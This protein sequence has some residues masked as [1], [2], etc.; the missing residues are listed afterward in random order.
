MKKYVIKKGQHNSGIHL[1]I[2]FKKEI[3][4]KRQVLFDES[5]EYNIQNDD[6]E[7]VNKLFGVSFGLHHK[8]SARFGWRWSVDKRKIEILTYT[9]I[10]GVRDFVSLQF[11][12]L[13]ETL[14]LTLIAKADTYYFKIGTSELLI[15]KN[16]SPS[17]GYFLYPY[18]GGNKVAPHNIIIN[19]N[20]IS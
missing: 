3:E 6:Q 10:D 20:K 13:N 4:M 16:I 19:I 8:N 5:C 14:T 17:Y 2:H 7:D 9:Y 18:F 12:D 1:S 11:V 15:N